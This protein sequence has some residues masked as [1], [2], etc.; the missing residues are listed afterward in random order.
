MLFGT[1]VASVLSL[2]QPISKHRLRTDLG[3]TANQFER[4]YREALTADA[5]AR[6][7]SRILLLDDVCTEGSTLR[8]AQSETLS[9]PRKF[10]RLLVLVDEPYA[11]MIYVAVHSG[12]RVSELIGLRWEDI[13]ADSL[14]IDERYCRGD[15]SVTKTPDGSATIAVDPPVIERIQ[16]LRTPRG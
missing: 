13:H 5:G 14:T 8:C 1:T 12:L 15:W 2:K 7:L 9:N 6:G 4:R 3:L 11:S 16:R 10:D